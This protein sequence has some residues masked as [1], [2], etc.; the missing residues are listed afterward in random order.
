MQRSDARTLLGYSNTTLLISYSCVKCC[1][2]NANNGGP[3]KL[4]ENG[5]LTF[6]DLFKMT[7]LTVDTS[8]P[9]HLT[10]SVQL[11]LQPE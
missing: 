2:N 10:G 11:L 5:I 9:F 8:V 7:S 3:L 1:S 4:L 6:M